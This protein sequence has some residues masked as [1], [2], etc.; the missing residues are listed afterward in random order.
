[1]NQANGSYK[2]FQV[3]TQR[4]NERRDMRKQHAA[5]IQRVNAIRAARGP[6]HL[7][8]N[9]SEGH[10]WGRFKRRTIRPLA[11]PRGLFRIDLHETAK[12]GAQ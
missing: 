9:Q 6:A 12:A 1:M 11:Y 5:A 3:E 10:G 2:N 7:E 8:P 4:R